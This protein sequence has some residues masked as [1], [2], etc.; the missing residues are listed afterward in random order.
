MAKVKAIS[1]VCVREQNLY[2]ESLPVQN[3]HVAQ[4]KRN[5]PGGAGREKKTRL[6]FKML[7]M[8]SF[9]EL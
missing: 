2:Q 6:L 7:L 8:K 5:C 4:R 9:L 1:F 3:D